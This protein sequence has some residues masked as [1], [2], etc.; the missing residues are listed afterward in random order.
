MN[1]SV[2]LQGDD[3]ICLFQ[4]NNINTP[5]YLFSI[6]PHVRHEVTTNLKYCTGTLKFILDPGACPPALFVYPLNC[7]LSPHWVKCIKLE[8]EVDF[9]EK[10]VKDKIYVFL[11]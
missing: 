4:D 8:V 1:P 5:Q 10:F 6:Q 9:P 2:H 11:V 7:N 3:Y